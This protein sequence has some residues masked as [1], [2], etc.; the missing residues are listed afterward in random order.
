M[1]HPRRLLQRL[2]PP[3]PAAP[4]FENKLKMSV[5]VLQNV[6]AVGNCL[7]GALLLAVYGPT[8]LHTR[9]WP[10]SLEEQVL[11]LV[12]G[13]VLPLA[14]LALRFPLVAGIAQFSAAFIGNQL[15][16]D[17]P[18]PTLRG[19]S[20]ASMVLA[21]VILFI[22]VFRGIL[23]ITQEAFGESEDTDERRSAGAA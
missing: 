21:I 12:V 8:L 10:P 15:L 6:F 3:S 11:L 22:A 2:P 19:C 5:R 9:A 17:A 1:V 18:Y 14:V 4:F 23:E 7:F 20:S 13:S 16:H